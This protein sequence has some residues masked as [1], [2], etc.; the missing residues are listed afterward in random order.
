MPVG[1][2]G[3]SAEQSRRSGPGPWC[4]WLP[5][6]G[7]ELCGPAAVAAGPAPRKPVETTGA[8]LWARASWR[9]ARKPPEAVGEA[10]PA[11]PGAPIEAKASVIETGFGRMEG[12]RGEVLA[13]AVADMM[14]GSWMPPG[15]A[16]P[17]DRVD[18]GGEA[19]RLAP[20]RCSWMGEGIV[21]RRVGE[22]P[23]VEEADDV[24]VARLRRLLPWLS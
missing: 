21:A 19:D 10:L 9:G 4:C 1:T 3:G 8:G 13:E 18:S 23:L 15:L 17:N 22:W 14:L 5:P 16:D 11:E 2:G 20:P 24:D 6:D 7:W 12:R